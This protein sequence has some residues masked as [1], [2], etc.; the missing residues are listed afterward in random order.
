MLKFDFF[1]KKILRLK[2]MLYFCT[3][4]LVEKQTIRLTIKISY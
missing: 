2:K 4:I 1:E 3:P